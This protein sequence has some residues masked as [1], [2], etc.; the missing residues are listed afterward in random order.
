MNQSRLNR[1]KFAVWLGLLSLINGALPAQEI[2]QT[3]A[4]SYTRYELLE[5]A[6]QSFR[7]YYDV[8]ATTPGAEYY[9]NAIR[10]GSEPTVHSVTDLM[11][12]A[13]LEWKLVDGTEAQQSGYSN[14]NT[15]GQYI[16]VSLARP[17]PKDGEAR[18]RIDKTY[19]DPKSYFSEDDVILFD[20]SLGIKRNSVVLPEGY[21]LTACNYPSQI[22]TQS[23]GR[24]KVSFINRGP[25]GVPY[26]LQARKLPRPSQLRRTGEETQ[27]KTNGSAPVAP[28]TS[29][30]PT[31]RDGY[32]FTERAFHDREIVYF[33]KQPETHSFFLYHDY[34]ETRAGIDKYLNVVRKGSSAS[35]PSA[36]ILD[37]GESLKVERLKGEQI[38]TRGIDVGQPVTPETEVVVIWFDPVKQGQSVRLR[39]TETYT[40]ANRY[41]LIGDELIWDREF[42]RSRNTVILPENWFV[43]ANAIPATVDETE[44]GKIR[45]NY[46][47]DRPGNIRVFF[48]ARRR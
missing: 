24:I 40:D 38:T 20:R 46:V 14:I 33:L 18:I 43:T 9:F 1:I 3:Q 42:G 29:Y 16:R 44:D 28:G 22:A 36:Q 7:I 37:T 19:K 27:S 13:A 4:D 47:N 6:S 5:P 31:A 17:V 8:S 45:L 2:R 30:A 11:T 48:K 34:T 25:T 10:K 12:G 21:E 35:E 23:D 39:I 15:D 32:T 26:K 41:L